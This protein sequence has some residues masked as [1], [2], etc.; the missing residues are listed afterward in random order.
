[1]GGLAII[2]LAT[3]FLVKTTKSGFIPTEDQGF[4]AMSVSTPSGTSL[5]G[6]TKML[7]EAEAKVRAL[8]SA[9]FVTAISGF[10]LLTIF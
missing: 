5:A 4:I 9:R 10:N 7:N 6:T 8:P 2:T 1:M 3:V